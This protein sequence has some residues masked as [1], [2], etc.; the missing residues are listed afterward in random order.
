MIEMPANNICKVARDVNDYAFGWLTRQPAVKEES[1]TD[2]LLDY[3]FQKS[4]EVRYYQFNRLE[5]AHFSGA[6]WDWWLLLRK[7]CHKLRVQA[8]KVRKGH[9]HHRQLSHSNVQGYQIDLLL[10]TSAKFN[11]YPLYSLYGFTEGVE[12]CTKTD[13]P[14]ALSICSA[15]EIY[16]LIFGGPKRR[17]NSTDLLRLSI[18]LE[19]L[20]C[21]PLIHESPRCGPELLF[22]HYFKPPKGVERDFIGDATRGYEE[23]IPPI[24]LS[25]FETNEVNNNTL[26]LLREYQTIFVGSNGLSIVRIE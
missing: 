10:E 5:E 18:P 14:V 9:D 16:D 8:K 22:E 1:I 3:F 12:K 26:G 19:C 24:I 17:I 2:W 11:F 4:N 6:D 15:Q 13:R 25:L 20:F 21:C 23:T 7:G